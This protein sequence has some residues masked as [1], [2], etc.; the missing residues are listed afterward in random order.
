MSVPGGS[1]AWQSPFGT[2]SAVRDMQPYP[3]M[4]GRDIYEH[5]NMTGQNRSPIDDL[6][7]LT[8]SGV[9]LEADYPDAADPTKN[10]ER[11]IVDG[12]GVLLNPATPED[13]E[14]LPDVYAPSK[15]QFIQ[16]HRDEYGC[17]KLTAPNDNM[18]KIY[19]APLM[20][21][22]DKGAEVWQETVI[23]YGGGKPTRKKGRTYP[24]ANVAVFPNGRG[25][26]YW[27]QDVWKR[28]EELAETERDVNSGINLLPIISGNVGSEQQAM[29]AIR[30]A[31]HAIIF[32]GRV[33]VNRPISDTKVDQILS[34][35]IMKR[36]DWLSSLNTLEQDTPDRPV[37]SD[38]E[39]RMQAMK[40]YVRRVRKIHSKIMLLLGY[41]M[42][43]DEIVIQS[44]TDRQAELELVRA[45]NPP[46]RQARELR[47]LGV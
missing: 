18:E 9:D 10:G 42:T 23:D 17:L 1:G 35:Y 46:D 33:D 39:I 4:L 21:V 7:S 44:P 6:L 37:A 19:S 40:M 45:I 3:L 29:N 13:A 24:L 16:Y 8:L 41:T 15:K 12:S 5:R 20:S 26:L 34:V 43:Y 38:R 22:W 27:A 28:M 47:L 30:K 11:C 14:W 2:N 25:I 36:E 31:K 32:P